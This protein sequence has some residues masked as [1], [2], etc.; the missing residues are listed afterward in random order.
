M[1]LWNLGT[2]FGRLA[3]ATNSSLKYLPT[4][5]GTPSVGELW[6]I[7]PTSVPRLPMLENP[8]NI[9]SARMAIDGILRHIKFE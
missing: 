5:L 8:H 2:V 4:L 3:S 6:R 7:P 1:T 9:D